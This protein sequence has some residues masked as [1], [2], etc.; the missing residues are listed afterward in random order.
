MTGLEVSAG[1][2]FVIT[3]VVHAGVAEVLAFLG[4]A[5]ELPV[6][7]SAILVVVVGLALIELTTLNVLAILAAEDR[8]ARV[9]VY[10]AAL[11][12]SGSAVDRR[13]RHRA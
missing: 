8:G 5:I 4:L 3:V 7:L 13:G 12:A 9:T 10:H 2:G 11:P 1:R 6:T